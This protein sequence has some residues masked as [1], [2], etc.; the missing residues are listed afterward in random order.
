M[1]I[2]GKHVLLSL[3]FLISGFLIAFVYDVSTIQ[4]DH[5][6]ITEAQW[7]EENALRNDIL[8]QQE[9]NRELEKAVSQKQTTIQQLEKAQA[10]R[11]ERTYELVQRLQHLRMITGEV[12]VEGPGVI[13]S[14]RDASYI[15]NEGN[16]NQY[17][18]HEQDI[19]RV[20]YELLIAGAE[21][22]A[23]NG[24]RLTDTSHISCVGPVVEVDG[25][26][27]FAPFKVSAIGDV[28][29]MVQSLNLRGN[30]K[31]QLVQA[32]IEVTI[33]KRDRIVMDPSA[34]EEG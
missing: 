9:V 25:H 22:I 3:V 6:T 7:E 33:S 29:N 26:Q 34:R 23:V 5:A 18:V 17:I 1:K 10:R 28:S 20:I 31:D 21:A 11:E 8:A 27:Y 2:K 14:L 13:V 32:G 15:P 4:N 16:P 24:Q 30:I 19:Q 12:K